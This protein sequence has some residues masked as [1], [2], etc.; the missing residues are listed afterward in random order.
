MS[1]KSVNLEKLKIN[2]SNPKVLIVIGVSVAGILILTAETR[3]RRL[4]GRHTVKEDYGAFVERF[5]LLPFPQLPPPAAKQL[6]SGLTFAI[7][8]VFDV[9]EYVSGFGN[10]DWKRT[11]EEAGKTAIVVTTLLKNGATCVGKTVMDE[12][13]FGIT[14]EN[15]HYGTP[16]N[17]AMPS[18]IPGGPSGGSAVAVAAELVDFAI[19][20]DTIGGVRIPAAYCGVLGFR[21]SHG[22]ISTVGVLPNSQ[23]LDTVGIFARDPSVL[24]RVGH[25]LLQLNPVEPRRTRRIIVADDLF[26]LS[27]V[28]QQKTVYIVSKVTEKLSGYQPPKHMNIGQYILSNVP[29][30]KYFHEQTSNPQKGTNTLKALSSAML[31][32]QRYEFKTNHEEW[33]NTVKPRLG[34]GV[35]DQIHAAI[36][37]QHENIKA[38]YKVRTEMRA[39][40]CSLL[41][42]DGILVLPTVADTPLKLNSKKAML[43]EFHDRA[44]ALLSITT[45]SGCCQA[46]VPFGKHED[47]PVGVSFIAFHGSDKFLLDTVLDMYQSLQ[48]QVSA[49]TSLPPSLDL[50]GNMDASELL[51]EKGNAAY[52][53]RQWNKAVSYYTEAIKLDES[54]ATFYCNRA[55]AYLELGCFQQAEEDCSRAI[56]LDKKN[57]KAYLRRGTARE[58]VLYYKEALQDFKHALVLEP[59]NKVAKG[60]EKR[61]R[62]LVS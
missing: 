42:D 29:S 7:N 2:V 25:V 20:T 61:L 58:S 44:F 47:C 33:I 15:S 23:S 16:T 38:Y 41:K 51:K 3:R 35:F 13:S 49:I 9:K 53:G 26:Q 55:A 19:G 59:Q 52:K 11:H 50:N 10:P 43:S 48:G 57:V 6:L 39:A 14:G 12:L 40:L 36:T 56:S 21:P 60:A 30:L 17:P 37:A 32:L 28:P 46:T 24:H 22:V 1:L 54:N 5:E 62:K 45:M 31:L 27:K 34:S 8:D 4:K 18:Y